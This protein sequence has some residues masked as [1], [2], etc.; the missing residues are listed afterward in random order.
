MADALGSSKAHSGCSQEADLARFLETRL[1]HRPAAG[2]GGLLW[3]Q[4]L[5]DGNNHPPAG[6]R[7]QPSCYRCLQSV[8]DGPVTLEWIFSNGESREDVEEHESEG[9]C[10]RA[11]G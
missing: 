2:E 9:R 5:R 10:S 1:P 7:P 8:S 6:A 11:P 4:F 3:P